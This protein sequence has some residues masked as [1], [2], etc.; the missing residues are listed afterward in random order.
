[1]SRTLLIALLAVFALSAALTG[2]QF[3]KNYELRLAY[4][5]HLADAKLSSYDPADETESSD[6]PVA[7]GSLGWWGA[8]LVLSLLGFGSLVAWEVSRFIGTRAGRAYYDET[9]EG[10]ADPDYEKAEEE[11]NRGHY[12]EAI[13]LM[14]EYLAFNPRRL[15]VAL[16]IAEIYEKDLFNPLAAALEY[17]EVLKHRLPPERWAWA[18]IHLCNLYAGKLHQPAKAIELLRRIDT[19]YGQTAAAAKARARLEQLVEEGVIEALPDPTPP[20]GGP[21]AADAPPAL[22]PGFRPR[23]D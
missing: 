21:S 8:G 4:Q 19:E 18:A 7:R 5:Q 3:A 9:Q 14:R 6:R 23:N 15:G 17:E 13:G 20:G 16:R 12:L 10:P 2:W 1:M 22:P 11:W